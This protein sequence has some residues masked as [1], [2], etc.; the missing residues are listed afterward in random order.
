MAENVKWILDQNPRAKIVLWAHNGHVSK[1][2]FG[3][4]SMGSALKQR[5]G[6]EMIVFGFSFS[7]GSFQAM[8]MP[9]GSMGG[10]RNFS[11]P[12]A[13]AD[14]FDGVLA[15]SGLPLFALDVRAA[16]EWF[17]QP[18]RTRQ[19]GCCYPV[20]QEYAFLGNV[21]V[22]DAFDAVLFVEKTTAARK[23]PG[24]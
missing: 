22:V 6:N 7:E 5:Y 11:V 19:I 16:P 3:G 15:Q 23:N 24:K 10:L 14:S 17:R 18:R 4:D 1:G 20:D 2:G 8:P 21:P 13:P 12:A 9:V